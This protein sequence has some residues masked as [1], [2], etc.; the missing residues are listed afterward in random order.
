MIRE[1]ERHRLSWGEVS[2][3]SD[4]K[5]QIQLSFGSDGE[6]HGESFPRTLVRSA[7]YVQLQW[8]QPN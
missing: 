5:T 1:E 3:A 4:N 6:K 2:I 8:S 7:F